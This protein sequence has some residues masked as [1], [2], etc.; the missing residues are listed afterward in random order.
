MIEYGEFE[1]V[2]IRVGQV[3]SASEFKEAHMPAYILEVDFGEEIGIKKSS[4]QLTNNYSLDELEGMLVAGVV[5]LG[6]KQIG[7][8]TSQVLIV[9][10]PDAKGEPVL[11]TPTKHVPLG[12]KL[13]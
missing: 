3:V 5:N 8:I 10:F 9:G 2:D 12:G 13:Y 6:E 11:V 7:P 4:A 1:Q